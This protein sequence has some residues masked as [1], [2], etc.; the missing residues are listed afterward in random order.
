MAQTKESHAST[1]R[2]SLRHSSSKQAS[3]RAS[4]KSSRKSSRRTSTNHKSTSRKSTSRKSTSRKSTSRKSSKAKKSR[5]RVKSALVSGLAT[6]WTFSALLNVFLFT[7]VIQYFMNLVNA[8]KKRHKRWTKSESAV[9]HGTVF[10][11]LV[12]KLMLDWNPFWK[13]T[14]TWEVPVDELPSPCIFMANHISYADPFVLC[15]A[16]P[17]AKAVGMSTLWDPHVVGDVFR[18][19][20]D[21]RK[22]CSFLSCCLSRVLNKAMQ[23]LVVIVM[24]DDDD[25]D[26]ANTYVSVLYVNIQD[27][28]TTT[29]RDC[30][31]R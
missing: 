5:G 14:V 6:V 24:H 28:G 29:C 2:G 18:N 15:G 23:P 31:A 26:D 13:R 12:S 7:W 21:L 30:Y 10:H 19:N 25:D 20:G 16:V 27:K 1:M 9:A 17:E 8:S 4:V 11:E 3:S 22:C